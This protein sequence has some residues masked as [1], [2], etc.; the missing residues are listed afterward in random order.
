MVFKHLKKHMKR[1]LKIKAAC[2][3]AHHGKKIAK[4]KTKK[5]FAKKGIYGRNIHVH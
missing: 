3:V 5:H 4:D 2:K 1:E